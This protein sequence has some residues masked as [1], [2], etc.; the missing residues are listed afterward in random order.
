M[1]G[2]RYGA[3][4]TQLLF[5]HMIQVAVYR[6][7]AMIARLNFAADTVK[8]SHQQGGEGQIGIRRRVWRAEF[9]PL[10]GRTVGERDTYRGTT[11]ALGEDQVD[12]SFISRYQSFI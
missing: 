9:N 10:G 6:T 2:T 11:I 12:R 3:D 5:R 7:V 1:Q 8:S 4:F